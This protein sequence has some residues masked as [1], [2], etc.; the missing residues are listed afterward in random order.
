MP[1]PQELR[2]DGEPGSYRDYT[3]VHEYRNNRGLV[4]LPVCGCTA[5]HKVIRLHGGFGTRTVKWTAS[6][7]GKPPM[8]P[9]A[10]DTYGDTLLS[11]TVAPALPVPNSTADGYDWVVSGV[12]EYVQNSPRVAG[13]NAFPAG[14]HPYLVYPQAATAADMIPP[15]YTSPNYPPSGR[16]DRQTE[17]LAQE[18]DPESPLTGSWPMPVFPAAYTST[19]IIGG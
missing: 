13:V 1:I 11:E 5:A 14:Q 12:Y 10:T 16:A 7:G 15:I 18:L 6:R 9:A 17:I 19:H 4:V 2:V 8:I 3:Q